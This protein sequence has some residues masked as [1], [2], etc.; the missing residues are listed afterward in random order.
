[1]KKLSSI[2]QDSLEYVWNNAPNITTLHSAIG[3]LL[4]GQQA[5]IDLINDD[6]KKAKVQL[7]ISSHLLQ[8]INGQH[9]DATYDIK[10]E[11]EYLE[12][13]EK[14]S[15]ALVS[16]ACLVGAALADDK[17]NSPIIEKYAK[18]LGIAAQI[19]NDLCALFRWD[20]KN[21]IKTKKFRF[22]SCT[23]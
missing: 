13:V 14:K 6:D 8:S 22:Q 18:N 10:T 11:S 21:D 19:D 5:I 16:M 17:N 20:E 4:A 3:L 12:M 7:Y 2:D 23:C 15:G 9:M 1:M